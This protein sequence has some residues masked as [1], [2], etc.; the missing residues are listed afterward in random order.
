MNRGCKRIAWHRRTPKAKTSF[1]ASNISWKHGK[2]HGIFDALHGTR[3][4]AVPIQRHYDE[5]CSVPSKA[6]ILI[7][8]KFEKVSDTA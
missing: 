8:A 6:A 5:G 2:W 3:P 4:V 7:V 1:G